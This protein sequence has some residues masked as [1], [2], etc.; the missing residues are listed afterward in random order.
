MD[1]GLTDR[2]DDGAPQPEPVTPQVLSNGAA[3]GG[4]RV[5][6][7]PLA[8]RL[9]REAGLD[10]ESLHGT[11]PNGRIVRR[12][13][14]GAVAARAAEPAAPVA[15]QAPQPEPSPVA[16]A[17]H[18]ATG[19][20]D[21]PHTRL[22]RTVAARLTQSV[23][24][25]PHFFVE[26]SARVD[27]LLALRA[28]LNAGGGTK[29]SVND[30]V[31]AA[32]ARAH[33]A[34]PDLNVTWGDDAVRRFTSVDVA[35]AVAT[36]RGLVTPV[37]R[38]VDQRTIGSIAA[39]NAD[40]VTRARAGRLRQ[41]E[42]RGRHRHRLE[43]RRLRRRAVQRDHQPAARVDPRRRRR[44]PGAR[45]RRRAARRRHRAARDPVGRP[46]PGRR[47]HRGAVGAGVH[48]PARA[49]PARPR[50]TPGLRAPREVGSRTVRGVCTPSE[51]C[52]SRRE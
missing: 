1:G 44:S 23:T 24:Q 9:A 10:V 51:R 40:L 5:F 12:D 34:V 41:D 6:S 45:R 38:G 39:A 47:R 4:G 17:P 11:G 18:P 19:Y 21:V 50:L 42:A 29:V 31:V 3:T 28:E 14:Q 35:V 2:A 32:V 7:S 16:Q 20:E 46:P 37:L 36:D 52:R 22:R 13:V 26:G 8:R 43:P 33:V 30:L 27:A 49:P 25:A 48:R 15:A